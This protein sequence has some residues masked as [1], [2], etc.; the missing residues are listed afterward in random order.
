MVSR[1]S[2][3]ISA[4][5]FGPA[6]ARIDGHPTVHGDPYRSVTMAP[7]SALSSAPAAACTGEDSSSSRYAPIRPEARYASERVLLS[8]L[9]SHRSAM[10]AARVKSAPMA[11]FMPGLGVP[12]E[13]L[14]IGESGPW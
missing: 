7:A 10:T 14:R 13:K 12:A 2:A 9:R 6:A 3:R 1:I 5:I 4:W 11:W 8:I